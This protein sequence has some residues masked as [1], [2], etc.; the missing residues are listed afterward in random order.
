MRNTETQAPKVAEGPEFMAMFDW[1]RKRNEVPAPPNS[2]G[3]LRETLT[4]EAN[5]GRVAI[6]KQAVKAHELRNTIGEA[7]NKMAD[8]TLERIRKG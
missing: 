7:L 3:E 1:F 4:Q 8:G 6:V 5:L 2:P